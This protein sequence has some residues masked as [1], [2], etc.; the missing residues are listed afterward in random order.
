M[1]LTEIVLAIVFS[2]LLIVIMLSVYF[3]CKSRLRQIKIIKKAVAE[4][5]LGQSELK[6]SLPEYINRTIEE[7]TSGRYKPIKLR[8]ETYIERDSTH[9]EQPA[10]KNNLNILSAIQIQR[11]S[12]KFSRLER[13][14]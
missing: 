2:G 11:T 14:I 6:E 5:K 4:F 9:F 1:E 7:K 12:K 10:A 3:V 13:V 8:E